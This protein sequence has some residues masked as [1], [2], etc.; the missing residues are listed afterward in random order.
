M[1]FY[2]KTVMPPKATGTSL[3]GDRSSGK[4]FKLALPESPIKKSSSTSSGSPTQTGSFTQKSKIEGSSIQIVTIKPNSSTQE[5]PKP[6]TGKQIAVDYAWSIQTLQALQEMGLAK[7]PQLTKKTW[8]D[9]ASESDD[10]SETSLQNIIQDSKN[11]K[12]I[13]DSKGK[14][15][16]S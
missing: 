10:D 9:M 12:T 15:T 6:A 14:Q 2:R 5:S 8:A 13:V 11:S 16:L 7:L 3:R 4:S 1:N